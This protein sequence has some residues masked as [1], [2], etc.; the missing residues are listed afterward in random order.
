MDMR[1]KLQSYINMNSQQNTEVSDG[2]K[3]CYDID[4][5]L[6][7]SIVENDQGSCFVV[8]KEYA[9]SYLYGGYNLGYAREL[10]INN[11]K[12]VCKDITD[13]FSIDDFL[14]L[15]TETTGLCGGVGTVAFLVGVGYYRED[16]FFVKQFF[17]RDY[18]EEPALLYELSKLFEEF[19]ALITY[20]GKSFDAGVLNNRYLMNRFKPIFED[21][22][23]VDLLHPSRVIWK[24]SLSDVRLSTLEKEILSEYRVD[25]IPGSMIP[26]A[27]FE[28]LEEKDASTIVK[29]LLHNVSDILSMTSVLMRIHDI[30]N[31]PINSCSCDEEL[32]GAGRI[33][34]KSREY[35]TVIK[36]LEK[37]NDIENSYMR[38][39]VTRSL[40]VAYKRT[41][42][43]KEALDYWNKIKD[44]SGE[45]DIFPLVELAKYYEHSSKD[46]E[47]AILVTETAMKRI[48]TAG[49]YDDKWLIELLKRIKRL[50]RKAGFKKDE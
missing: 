34:E 21:I 48:G 2:A 16:K 36:C 20:N 3:N 24:N 28:Y 32:A 37:C 31:D 7:G 40:S 49:I 43:Y 14:F 17:M 18:D 10:R 19:K 44:I 11:L 12:A 23:H 9:D 13:E 25:D 5:L 1:S 35:N 46:Y 27:Y 26:A 22:P 4:R 29:V 50:R 42:K 8:T 30:I 47:M 38:R 33:F 39:R 6:E 15:D 45:L 41:G